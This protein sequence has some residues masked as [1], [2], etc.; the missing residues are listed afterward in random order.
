MV[1]VKNPPAN[2]GDER[3]V[4]STAGW[5]KPPGVGHGYLL[6]YSCL[7]IPWVEE[8]GG[9]QSVGMQRVGHN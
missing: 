6:Q 4:G 5:G 1:L 2:E 7:E 8:P 9:L 3:Y